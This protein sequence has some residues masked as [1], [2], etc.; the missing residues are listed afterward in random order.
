MFSE[1]IFDLSGPCLLLCKIEITPLHRIKK[2]IIGL[3]W[4][5]KKLLELIFM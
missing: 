1:R 5:H 4:L 2:K 3:S